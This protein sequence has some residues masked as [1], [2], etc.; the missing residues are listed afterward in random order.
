ME[1]LKGIKVSCYVWHATQTRPS[2]TFPRISLLQGSKWVFLQ[3][4]KRA[5]RARLSCEMH[6]MGLILASY[7][8]I[9]DNLNPLT[10]LI[11][12]SVIYLFANIDTLLQTITKKISQVCLWH[13][14]WTLCRYLSTSLIVCL[15]CMHFQ[16]RLINNSLTQFREKDI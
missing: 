16:K 9:A 2:C 8:Y 14:M 1:I 15:L 10:N 3:K 6:K 12:F 7:M 13:A 11:R 4:G 5:I